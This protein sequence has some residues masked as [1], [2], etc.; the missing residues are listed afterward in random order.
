MMMITYVIR[1]SIPF[2]RQP[3]VYTAAVSST[4]MEDRNMAGIDN[5][6]AYGQPKI[7]AK[8][9]G[10]VD[11]LIANVEAAAIAR[12]ASSLRL[13]GGLVDAGATVLTLGSFT[14]AYWLYSRHKQSQIK[15]QEEARSRLRDIVENA[16]S[17]GQSNS[18]DSRC[19]I[20]ASVEDDS[21]A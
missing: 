17:Q 10:G 1:D 9:A 15:A 5:L 19:N 11:Q 14:F 7:D 6:G 2:A 4:I 20:N 21:C 13:Q 16:S 18:N 8:N 3:V 12:T